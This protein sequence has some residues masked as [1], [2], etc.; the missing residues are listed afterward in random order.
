MAYS[1]CCNT[2]W[3]SYFTPKVVCLHYQIIES[4]Y[5][6][7]FTYVYAFFKGQLYVLACNDVHGEGIENAPCNHLV[8]IHAE[9]CRVDLSYIIKEEDVLE[10]PMRLNP[11]LVGEGKI[12]VFPSFMILDYRYPFLFLFFIS[13]FFMVYLTTI[14]YW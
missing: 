12:N 7:I 13:L 9:T 2:V 1:S 10:F 5:N 8:I 6:Q 11:Q 4:V 14:G 3:S